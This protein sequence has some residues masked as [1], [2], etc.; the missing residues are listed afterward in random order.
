MALTHTKPAAEF[1]NVK[2]AQELLGVSEST[3]RRALR[4]G[5]VQKFKVGRRTVL[6]REQV[7]ALAKPITVT[8][9]A[10]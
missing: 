10:A 5:E 2:E 6:R 4:S 1:V 9:T 7:I 8:P 3:V